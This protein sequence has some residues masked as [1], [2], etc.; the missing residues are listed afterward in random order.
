MPQSEDLNA[1]WD[2][3]L[4]R[5]IVKDIQE[6][7]SF[8]KFLEG[9]AG[10]SASTGNT[11][12]SLQE[13]NKAIE[14]VKA[15]KVPQDVCQALVSLRRKLHAEGIKPSPRRFAACMEFLKAEA[16]MDG[17]DSVCTDDLVVLEHCLW[18]VPE[19]MPKIAMIL[20]ELASPDLGRVI[21][22]LD[23]SREQF[24]L[25]A[26][27]TDPTKVLEATTKLRKAYIEIQKLAQNTS[28]KAKAKATE[29]VDLVKNWNNILLKKV[30]V[31]TL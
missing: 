4:V 12:I 24:D 16:W 15:V 29:G 3:T 6:D 17:R 20:S 18:E 19:Q 25:C 5:L 21:E 2:R 10:R 13:L 27:V 9:K 31:G 28:G 1:F 14:E 7:S 23:S 30:G 8:M 22:I 11:T 26:N